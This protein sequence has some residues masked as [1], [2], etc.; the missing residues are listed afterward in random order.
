MYS[1]II[2]FL[3]YHD[4]K[5]SIISHSLHLF[6]CISIYVSLYLS[7]CISRGADHYHYVTPGLPMCLGDTPCLLDRRRRKEAIPGYYNYYVI[8]TEPGSPM[9]LLRLPVA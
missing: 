2:I 4:D 7:L 6:L 9:I 8:S 1:I 5:K 3:K